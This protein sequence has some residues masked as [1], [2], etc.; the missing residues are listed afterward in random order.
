MKRRLIAP[1]AG[2]CAVLLAGC[3]ASLQ[4]NPEFRACA[5][6]CTRQQD[7]CMVNAGNS[8]AVSRCNAALDA[9]VVRCEQKFSRYVQP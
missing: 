5:N 9:C 1:I 2:L 8:A 6:V 4:P 7:A 3:G